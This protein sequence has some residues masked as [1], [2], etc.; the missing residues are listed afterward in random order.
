MD[1]I[2]KKTEHAPLTGGRTKKTHDPQIGAWYRNLKAQL[3]KLQPFLVPGR[4][5]TFQ[6]ITPEESDFYQMLIGSI[7]I[8]ESVCAVFIPPSVVQAAMWSDSS[9]SI[10]TG[11]AGLYGIS[12]D[13]GAVVAQR[14]GS[15]QTIVNA[16]FAFPPLH[17]GIDVYDDG[18]LLAGYT[19]QDQQACAD[20]LTDILSIYLK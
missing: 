2:M 20:E 4:L 5:V 19:Y 11:K 9:D 13:A 18:K 17:P 10:A 15:L 8:P 7:R 14:C 3:H 12:P 16:L 1:V 6:Q